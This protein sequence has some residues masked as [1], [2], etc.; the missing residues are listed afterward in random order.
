MAK[1]R[2]KQITSFATF[3]NNLAV[4]ATSIRKLFGLSM[5]GSLLL[6]VVEH[7]EVVEEG[8][9]LHESLLETVKSSSLE[10]LILMYST[11][12]LSKDL[13]HFW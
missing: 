4:D 9:S 7:K 10:A 13:I 6:Q 5:H 1:M 2:L 11:M 8:I 12:H 3:G